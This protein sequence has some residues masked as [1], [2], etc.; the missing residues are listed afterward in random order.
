MKQLDV[1]V[2][3]PAFVWDPYFIMTLVT[4]DL[5]PVTLTLLNTLKSCFLTLVTLNF[6]L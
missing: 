5:D 3:P 1:D 6:D 4:L 2:N